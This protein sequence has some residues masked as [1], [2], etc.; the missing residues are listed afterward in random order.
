[1]IIY[2]PLWKTIEKKGTTLHSV[3]VEANIAP[4]TMTKIRKGK[5]VSMDVLNRMCNV[6]GCGL[7]EII[8]FVHEGDKG[9]VV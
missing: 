9:G 2:D 6:L 5:Y 8:K 7:E 3:M 1:M 4:N